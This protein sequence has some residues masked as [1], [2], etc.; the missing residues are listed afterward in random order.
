MSRLER[1]G[2]PGVGIRSRGRL[3]GA[4]RRV[5]G[6]GADRD[7]PGAQ[8]GLP[9]GLDAGANRYLTKSSFQD[10]TFLETIVDLIG[11]PTD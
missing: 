11:E 9:R 10:D 5:R 6:A 8:A 7:Q 4:R 1:E 3:V 2:V